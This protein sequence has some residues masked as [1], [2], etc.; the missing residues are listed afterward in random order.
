MNTV[1]V[2]GPRDLQHNGKPKLNAGETLVWT[3]SKA[4]DDWQRELSPFHLGPVPLYDGRTARCMENA[5]QYAKVYAQHADAS[6]QPLP[7]YWHW[8][9]EGWAKPAVRYPM[10]KGAKPLYLLWQGERLGYIEA[11][12][13][14]YWRLYRD[15]VQATAGFNT[16]RSL[17]EQGPLCLFD[18]DGYD[19]E[20]MGLT[21]ADVIRLTNRPMGHAFVL[22]AMLTQGH[23]VEAADVLEQEAAAQPVQASLF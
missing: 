17:H 21:L 15:A 18:F 8:A 20:A 2:I 9:E 23:R 5:W 3:V 11:R 13:R 19:H 14:V 16:L 1:R 6:G 10:G 12:Q 4:A 22:K 7:H